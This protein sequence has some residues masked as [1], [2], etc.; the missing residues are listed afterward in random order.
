MFKKVLLN[1]LIGFRVSGK[2]GLRFKRKPEKYESRHRVFDKFINDTNL[3]LHGDSLNLK[4][5]KKDVVSA[6]LG[7]LK[8]MKQN[9]ICYKFFPILK[10]ITGRLPG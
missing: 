10:L 7:E 6:F 5:K 9:I 2:F 1:F 3:Q 4:K 8:Y